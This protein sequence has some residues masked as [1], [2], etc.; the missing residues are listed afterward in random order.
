MLNG[1]NNGLSSSA[2]ALAVYKNE[3][4]AGGSFQEAGNLSV[5]HIARWD[6]QK[7]RGVAG[8]VN[9]PITA[10]KTGNDEALYV[11]GNFSK[12]GNQDANNIAK[13]DG[14]QWQALGEGVQG[15]VHGLAINGNEIYVAGSFRSSGADSLSHVKKWNGQQWQDL[16]GTLP[17]ADNEFA[18]YSIA[19]FHNEVFVGVDNRNTSGSFLAKWNGSQWLEIV[20]AQAPVFVLCADRENLYAGGNFAKIGELQANGLAKWNGEKWLGL[21]NHDRWMIYSLFADGGNLYVGGRIPVGEHPWRGNSVAA[22]DGSQW[23]FMNLLWLPKDGDGVLPFRFGTIQ[24]LSLFQGK[25]YASGLFDFAG[26]LEN[27]RLSANIA[28]WEGPI[29]SNNRAPRWSPLPNLTFREDGSNRLELPKYISDIDDSLT[30]LRFKAEVL[31]KQ[32]TGNKWQKTSALQVNINPTTKIANFKASP[33]SFGVFKVAFTVTDPGGQSDTTTMHVRVNPRNDAPRFANLPATITFRNN[34]AKRLLMWDFVSDPEDADST[35]H[36]SFSASKD[37]LKRAFDEKTG[38]LTLTAPGFIGKAQLFISVNDDSNAVARD[39]IAVQVDRTTE[40]AESNS[41]IPTEFVLLQNYPNPFSPLKRGAF[42]NPTTLI[43]FGLPQ[44]SEVQL[45]VF[46]LSGQRV[47]T[48]LNEP[49]PA[50]FHA[51]E[52]NATGLS[53]GTYFYRLTAGSFGERKKFLLVK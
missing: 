25:F 44:T 17:I 46:D 4:Y 16:S 52:F 48:L 8:G 53:S 14:A 15:G 34:T 23:M 10:M 39:T 1:K 33:D 43:R 24:A 22:W 7:W 20:E 11:V 31:G 50:G 21:G 30:A 5:N 9:G 6:G 12:V 36:F 13:W 40:V 3:L 2:A 41:E 45:E 35:L 29:L 26:A 42:G 28:A 51:V 47:A 37:S 18:K 27:E 19:T 38:V 49:K 32:I